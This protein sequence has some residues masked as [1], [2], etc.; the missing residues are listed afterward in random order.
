MKIFVAPALLITALILMLFFR[1]V[2]AVL[3]PMIVVIFGVIWSFGTLVLFGYKITILTSLLAPLIIV[4]G[5]PNCILLLN[6]Y[7]QEFQKHGNKIKALVRTIHRIG[8][9]TF[10]PMSPPLSVFSFSPSHSAV[11]IEFGIITAINVMLT[12]LISLFLIPIV[13]SFLPPPS[14]K[15][16]KHLDR[17]AINRILHRVD[18]WVHHYRWR[19]YATVLVVIGISLYGANKITTVG[20]VVDDLPKKD[21]I[22]TDLKFFESNFRV[23]CRSRSAS[24][25]GSR[26]ARSN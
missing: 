24:T 8:A 6:M 22:Y 18:H 20:Y 10:S 14:A 25:H 3:F 7:Q 12:Y 9:S 17:R 13:F 16:I 19:V 11:L 23:C 2:Q 21:V 26:V 1:S 15:Q 5:I 4:I